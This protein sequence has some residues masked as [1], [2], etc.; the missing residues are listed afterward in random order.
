MAN[1][2]EKAKKSIDELLRAAYEEAAAAGELPAGAELK[3]SVDIPKDAK[4]GDYAANHAMAGA[5]A[6]HQPP[7]KIA[8]LL[9]QHLKLEGSYFES[10]EIAGPGFLN[11]R[12]GQR[13]YGEVLA[14]VER[15][16][17]AYGRSEER[18][19]EKVMV[20]FV[21]A[22]PTGPMTIGNARGGVLGD[23][24]ATLLDM[25]G[26]DVS[27]EFYVN[28]AGNQVDKFGRSIDARY[29]EL[30]GGYTGESLREL[31]A[32]GSD[33]PD[34]PEDG[35]H[36]VDI[37]ELAEEIIERDGGS[38]L[39]E[40]EETRKNAFISYGLPKNIALMEKHLDRYGIHFDRWFLESS[41][42]ESG[43]VKETVDLLTQSGLT[44]EK[45]GAVWLKNKELGAEKDEVLCRSNG[46]YT[47]YAVD[48]AY[49]RN[50]FIERGFDRVIDVWGADHHGHA[51][52]F[53]K[54]MN[55]S[56]LG[57]NGRRLDFLIMQMVRLVRDGETVKVSKRSGKALTLNDLLD[58]IGVDACRFFF[59]AKPET[60]L[61]FDLDL[62]IRQD[63]ENPVYYV[64]YAHARICSLLATMAS[65]GSPVPAVKD[66]DSALLAS[67]Q[68]RDL[69]KQ[70]SALPEEV[71]M[72][73]RDYD[74][75]RINRYVTELSARFHRFYNAC[76]LREAEPEVRSARLALCAAAKTAI[77]VCLGIIGVS[78]P[79][80]M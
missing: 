43:Y 18:T 76:R 33:A 80:K 13:W 70:L 17:M 16:G 27:R 4:N 22:S 14:A 74:P 25:A 35:Y 12:L 54:T 78:A 49:H 72:A 26:A 75:S 36:G 28:D 30:L 15:E 1:L 67:E 79:E 39:S 34:F 7:R 41:L 63:S 24:L 9:V 3:G 57:L 44:Y 64:Q 38:H 52:R 69:I 8:E 19:G 5:K 47:Y 58:E 32:S 29:R 71:R 73:A 55:A 37:I 61:E 42:H 10:C 50:K 65:E 23:T 21:S 45:D 59:N 6:L 40:D 66:I 46:F 48:I 20:E 60:H 51:I 53:G 56:A 2:I 62:A 11:F 31:L 77:A 68:E